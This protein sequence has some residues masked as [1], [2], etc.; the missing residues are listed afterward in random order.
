MS[1]TFGENCTAEFKIIV[2][3]VFDQYPE[4]HSE[5]IEVVRGEI[6][7]STMYARPIVLWKNWWK[8][9]DYYKLKVAYHVRDSEH[10]EVDSLD[11]LVLEGWIAHEMGHIVD[12]LDH[13]IVDMAVYG[14]KYMWSD[15]FARKVEHNADMIAVHHGFYEQIKITKEFLFYHNEIHPNYSAKMKKTYMSLEDLELCNTDYERKLLNFSG[16]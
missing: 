6:K 5:N 13:S 15:R 16:D 3:K 11:P 2:R 1:L 10:L 8:G 9:F 7:E 4:L 12:Y 14:L